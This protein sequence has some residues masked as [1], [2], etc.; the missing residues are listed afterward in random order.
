MSVLVAEGVV[1]VTADAK[2]VPGQISR[3]VEHGAGGLVGSGNTLGNN[4]LTGIGRG[5]LTVGKVTA[6]A[7][8]AASLAV[9]TGVG[10]IVANGVKFDAAMQ[11]YTAAFTPL[12]GGADAAHDKLQELSA[13]AAATPF[14]ISGL[15]SASQTLLSFGTTNAALLPDLKMLGDISQGNQEKLSG[16]ALVFGQVQSNGH[17]MGQDLLQMINQG[18]NPLPII[19]AKT[20]ESMTDLRTRMSQGK[21]TFD[22]VNAAMVEATSKGGMFYG[23]M[24]LGAKTLTGAWSSTGDGARILSGAMVSSLTPALTGVLNDG[25]NP[26]LGGLVDLVN[27]V[28]GAQGEVD[29]ASKALITQVDNLAPAVGKLAT[30]LGTVLTAIAPAIGSAIGSLVSSLVTLLPSLLTVAGQIVM[31]VLHAIVDNAPQ[32]VEAAVPILLGFVGG[33]IGALPM[34]MQTG[35]DVVLALVT[36]ITT[37]LPT[38]I[39]Q[40]VT[41]IINLLTTLLGPGNLTALLNAG[42]ALIMGLATGIIAALPSLVKA[43]PKLIV[44]IIDF[45]MDS[46]PLL[47][48][49]GIDLFLALV[50]ALPDIITG[51]VAAIP[52]IVT[53]LLLAITNPSTLEHLI[54]AGVKLLVSLVT[55]LPA[56]IIAIVKAVPD[57]ITGIVKAF[58]DP[59]VIGQLAKAGGDLIQGL[60]Q[61]I[62]AL[63]PWIWSKISGFA[64][65]IVNQIKGFFGIHSPSTLMRDEVGAMLGQGLAIGIT[66]STGI[67]SDAARAL[68]VSASVNISG[69]AG[70]TTNGAPSFTSSSGGDTY[71]TIESITLDAS[72][73]DDITDIVDM[74]K[75]LPQVARSGPGTGKAA[76]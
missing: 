32:L 49:A 13:F 15:A 60:W 12:L 8:G 34:L 2:G 74:V 19:A 37:S 46:L 22:E 43:L 4:L 44:G 59:K 41:G 35:I 27:G 48:D 66:D 53:G 16:L 3:D 73:I 52:K 21:V 6:V 30:N 70:I 31:T 68:G 55:D 62:S 56:I 20:G 7:L 58:G 17:L 63:G 5:L 10:A 14:T 42:L 45:L 23:S 26:L 38:L 71:V 18:F 69:G 54:L 75:E 11:N 29:K 47:I 28:D 65:G 1:E 39:P 61:G 64:S 72:S 51:L 40:V 33:L 57:I 67:V 9:A 76:A 24:D 50:G 25:I 36:G